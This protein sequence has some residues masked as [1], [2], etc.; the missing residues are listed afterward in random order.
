[1]GNAIEKIYVNISFIF[2]IIQPLHIPTP[3][4][5]TCKNIHEE[6]QM[7]LLTPLFLKVV[8]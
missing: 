8:A 1:M 5:K 2:C 3:K 7:K 6:K 4:P